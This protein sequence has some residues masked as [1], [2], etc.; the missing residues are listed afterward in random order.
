MTTLS[1]LL[2][3]RGHATFSELESSIANQ[4]LHGGHLA[5][6]LLEL[7][8]ANENALQRLLSEHH[9]LPVGPKGRLPK[10]TSDL[11]ERLPREVALRYHVFPIKRTQSTFEIAVCEPLEPTV[12]EQLERLVGMSLRVSVVTPLRLREALASARDGD[13]AGLALSERERWLLDQLNH[14]RTPSS[15]ARQ[16]DERR[17]AM[18]LFPAAAP[19]RRMSEHPDGVVASLRQPEPLRH[20]PPMPPATRRAHHTPPLGMGTSPPDTLEG[21]GPKAGE[22]QP[23]T[24]QP[25]DKPSSGLA[26]SEPPESTDD[27]G[28][29]TRPYTE[30]EEAEAEAEGEGE[31][32]RNTQPWRDD[33]DEEEDVP[34]SVQGEFNRSLSEAPPSDEAKIH[35]EHRRFRHRGPFTR[36][37]AE[38]AVSQSPDVLMVMEILVRYARQFF[39][40][41]VLFAVSGDV[42]EL[43]FAHGVGIELADFSLPLTAPS[44]LRG[45]F[46]SGDPVVS[47]LSYEG[48]DAIIRDALR[49]RSDAR[50]AVVPLCIR[51][52]VVALFYGDDR[53]VGVDRSAVADVTDFSEICAAEITRLIIARKKSGL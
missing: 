22:A 19:Y 52:R 46:R 5:T 10:V 27:P 21:V 47:E 15:E 34:V 35:E 18:A 41:C 8:V 53:D 17:R 4:A 12:M 42:A 48:V 39:E 43:R 31:G 20:T 6:N 16:A 2:L 3:E 38:M 24:L 36:A 11:E 40:R 9:Q 23:D 1:Q 33:S 49:V 13:T 51:E 44:V 7:G 28:R 37:Q 45:A 25:G 29:I 50:I 30:D 32:K 26:T 14:G